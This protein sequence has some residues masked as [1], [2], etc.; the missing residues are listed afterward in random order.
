MS[1]P[2]PIQGPAFA[3]GSF[4]GV[5]HQPSLTVEEI[6]TGI[7][8]TDFKVAFKATQA[9]RFIL[10]CEKNPPINALIDAGIVPKLVD[11]LSVSSPDQQETNAML[12]EAAW[13]LTNITAGNSL[14]TRVVVETGALPH[15]IRL[16]EYPDLNV[17]F[18]ALWALGNIACDGSELCNLVTNLGIIL[19]P[20]LGLVKFDTSDVFLHN[21]V[22]TISNLCRN[23]NPGL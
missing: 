7:F 15:F 18:Q 20:L 11:F 22:W 17:S 1:A 12:L 19:K 3:K 9:A 16:L 6:K 4:C 10:S 21:V 23:K 5:F 8:S 2:T 14:Q 13:A